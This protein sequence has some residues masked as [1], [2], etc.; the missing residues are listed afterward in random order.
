MEFK[1]PK[2]NQTSTV[3]KLSDFASLGPTL[4]KKSYSVNNLIHIFCML[5]TKEFPRTF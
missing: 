2:H 4:I 3:K 5:K 1:N